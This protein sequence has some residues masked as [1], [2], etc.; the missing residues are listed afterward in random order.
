[1]RVTHTPVPPRRPAAPAVPQ[2]AYRRL[3]ATLALGALATT[4][5]EVTTW[6][7]AA[8]ATL[9]RRLHDTHVAQLQAGSDAVTVA[10]P[11]T[12]AA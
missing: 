4:D 12:R 5:A 6:Y 1:M 2:M 10:A 9:A 7:D 3:W 8:S 11:T